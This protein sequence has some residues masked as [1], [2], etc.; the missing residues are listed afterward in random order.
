[1]ASQRF[2][3]R[4]VIIL[5]S[6]CLSAA[7]LGVLGV[8]ASLHPPF[9]QLILL[10]LVALLLIAYRLSTEFRRWLF[11][12]PLEW[13]V[14]VHLVRFVG[15]YFLWLYEHRRLPFAFGP[16][17]LGRHC[18][19]HPSAGSVASAASLSHHLSNL[20]HPWVGRYSLCCRHGEKIGHRGPRVHGGTSSLSTEP[21][22]HLYCAPNHFYACRDL[23]A[24][25]KR[26]TQSRRVSSPPAPSLS[27]GGQGGQWVRRTRG[28]VGSGGQGGQCA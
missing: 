5:L 2:S 24:I 7:L 6:W 15:F 3:V 11:S 18:G 17:R 12:V 26:P 4:V 1:M 25:E 28:S 20:E 22:P 13:L 19:G 21:P 8:I 16:G 9:P 10:G 23:S 27:T 14:S